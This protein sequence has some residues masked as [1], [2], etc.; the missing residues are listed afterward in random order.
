MQSKFP[1]IVE[2]V[3]KRLDAV[4]DKKSIDDIAREVI[5][6]KWGNGIDRK[7]KLTSA[8]YNY[9]EIQSAVN[10]LISGKGTIYYTSVEQ[11]AK[12]VIQGKWGNGEDRKQ[13]LEAAGY[14]YNMVQQ[15]VNELL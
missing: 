11:I 6:G 7:N 14:D 15:R 4:D 5:L 2:Q 13:K 8:G 9:D 12:E 3:N 10:L 1:W